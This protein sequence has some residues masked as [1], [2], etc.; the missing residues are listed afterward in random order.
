MTENN[1]FTTIENDGDEGR[2]KHSNYVHKTR[3]CFDNSILA[4]RDSHKS[5]SFYERL[6]HPDFHLLLH[7]FNEN[8]HN[9]TQKRRKKNEKLDEGCK[10]CTPTNL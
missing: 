1:H 7:E 5:H 4:P 8:T 2:F 9:T 10:V 6:F 3:R